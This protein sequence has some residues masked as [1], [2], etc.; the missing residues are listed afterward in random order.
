METAETCPLC[1]DAGIGDHVTTTTH[2][3]PS[4]KKKNSV[5][6][7]APRWEISVGFLWVLW[8]F[9]AALFPPPIRSNP[10]RF[11]PV[12]SNA[13]QF[14]AIRFGSTLF[15]PMQFNL[16]QSDSTHPNSATLIRWPSNFGFDPT[17]WFFD[18]IRQQKNEPSKF[19]S[20]G[21][22][23]FWQ[24]SLEKSFLPPLIKSK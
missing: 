17:F 19:C 15:G 1:D 12:R 11:D 8:V 4:L 21:S 6:D 2:T 3:P 9:G 24:F 16:A 18:L 22:L 14:G 7:D 10:I 20:V 23:G 13:I 5:H